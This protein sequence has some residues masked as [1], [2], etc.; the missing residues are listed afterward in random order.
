MVTDPSQTQGAVVVATAATSASGSPSSESRPLRPLYRPVDSLP[1]DKKAHRRFWDRER[2]REH[3]AKSKNRVAQLEAQGQILAE[4]LQSVT[5]ERDT[6]QKALIEKQQR[7]VELEAIVESLQAT[8]QSI[9]SLANN[10]TTTQ[11]KAGEMQEGPGETIDSLT[12][13]TFADSWPLNMIGDIPWPNEDCVNLDPEGMSPPVTPVPPWASLPMN[14]PPVCSMDSAFYELEQKF[15]MA[16]QRAQ[17]GRASAQQRARRAALAATVAATGNRV[18]MGNES[19]TETGTDADDDAD[20]DGNGNSLMLQSNTNKRFMA[21]LS[22]STFPQVSSL[23]N[24]SASVSTDN[25]G[26]SSHSAGHDSLENNHFTQHQRPHRG[27][28]H[29]VF[30]RV[31]TQMPLQEMPARF[32]AMWVVCHLVRWRLCRSQP[33]FDALPAFLHPTPTQRTV[34]HP[35]WIDT[36]VW[37]AARDRLI[38]QPGLWNN[39]TAFDIFRTALG[40]VLSV[41]WPHSLSDSLTV[42]PEGNGDSSSSVRSEGG[43]G[44][45]ERTNR[46]PDYCLSRAFQAHLHDLSNWTVDPSFVDAYPFLRGAMNERN[47]VGMR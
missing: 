25:D 5:R 30:A 8:L 7:I 32:A 40:Q 27:V 1:D 16:E 43:G 36:I 13:A 46:T 15:H 39:P 44:G 31:M 23:I 42:V 19:E 18:E 34:A 29:T 33:A 47:V 6:A 14:S 45:R 22:T 2:Q 38:T 28:A 24:P 41:G 17:A 3:R 4:Q 35:I 9:F 26:T 12:W 10:A 11:Y 21:E 37:P 20:T